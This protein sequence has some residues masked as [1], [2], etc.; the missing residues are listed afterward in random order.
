MPVGKGVNMRDLKIFGGLCLTF[1]TMI[2]E[3]IICTVGM[4]G[5]SLWCMVMGEKNEDW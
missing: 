5:I 1:V 3:A 2:V 4:I